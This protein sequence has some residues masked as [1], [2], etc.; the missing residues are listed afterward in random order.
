MMH[1]VALLA[2]AA[3]TAAPCVSA[4][5]LRS[6]RS[7]TSRSADRE[8]TGPGPVRRAMDN[9]QLNVGGDEDVQAITRD[10]THFLM[11]LH[12]DVESGI[13]VAPETE[14]GPIEERMQRLKSESP[15]KDDKED[16]PARREFRRKEA[17]I[18]YEFFC[19]LAVQS[20]TWKALT[21]DNA[22]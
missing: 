20:S 15:A 5:H 18:L 14:T 3:V 10:W 11:L 17:Q 19:A 16:T 1:K 8:N 22:Q 21:R 7:A 2:L 12:G 13:V 9:F 6:Y 4:L